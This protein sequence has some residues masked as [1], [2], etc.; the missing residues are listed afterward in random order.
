MRGFKKKS[1]VNGT[2]DVTVSRR[3]HNQVSVRL[4][5]NRQSA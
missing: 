5:I 4:V 2:L 3:I 1:P